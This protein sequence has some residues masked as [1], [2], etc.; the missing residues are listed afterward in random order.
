MFNINQIVK[1][2]VGQF[3]IIGFRMIGNEEYAQVKP[4]NPANQKAG[5]GELALPVSILQAI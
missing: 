5:R 1:A 4:Y 3:V 2:K